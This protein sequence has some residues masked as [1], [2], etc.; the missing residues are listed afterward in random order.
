MFRKITTDRAQG[1]TI[2]GELRKEFA[3]YT[4]TAR[5]AV[6][7]F[8]GSHPKSVYL[9]MLGCI[10]IS[11]GCFLFL[12]RKP[13]PQNSPAAQELPQ[14]L[15]RGISEVGG[16]LGMLREILE[17]QGAMEI[18]LEKG[19]LQT[20]DSLLMEKALDR[21]SQLQDELSKKNDIHP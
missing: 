3:R 21:I 13:P 8:L 7:N 19:S 12:P 16:T 10:A 4:G 18:L 11:L 1:A 2:L 20:S 14:P 6:L 9:G 5:R 17:L 15:S